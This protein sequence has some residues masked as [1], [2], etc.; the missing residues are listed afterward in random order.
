MEGGGPGTDPPGETTIR[1]K[2]AAIDRLK[3]KVLKLQSKHKARCGRS[4][5]LT[6]K[7][8][9]GTDRSREAELVT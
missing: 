7:S 1:L 3:L 9:N 5:S 2:K 4:A 8:K 6:H